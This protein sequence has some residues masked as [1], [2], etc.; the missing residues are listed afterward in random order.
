MKRTRPIARA[1]VACSS[2]AIGTSLP[3]P[4]PSARAHSGV[5]TET[6]GRRACCRGRC[7][8]RTVV[9]VGHVAAW[10]VITVIY[11]YVRSTCARNAY[12]IIHRRVICKRPHK[13]RSSS[14]LGVWRYY[15]INNNGINSESVIVFTIRR[16]IRDAVDIPLRRVISIRILYDIRTRAY[17]YIN[18]NRSSK[19]K[20]KKKSKPIFKYFGNA[21]IIYG[22]IIYILLWIKRRRKSKN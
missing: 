21:L 7:V 15:I 13:R 18:S 1:L 20:R 2:T 3:S 17:I 22:R 9:V 12:A 14:G 19:T 8:V 10:Q 16:Q 11:L 4:P 6:G 5:R